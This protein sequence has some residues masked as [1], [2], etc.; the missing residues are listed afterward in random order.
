MTEKMTK[1]KKELTPEEAEARRIRLKE[2]NDKISRIVS[3]SLEER[4]RD[5]GLKYYVWYRQYSFRLVFNLPQYGIVRIY[6]YYKD[7]AKMDL[8]GIIAS[9]KTLERITN[10]PSMR[11]V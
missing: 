5:S 1:S 3:A 7:F 11:K 4:L 9:V 10:T 6:V 8:D 2:K